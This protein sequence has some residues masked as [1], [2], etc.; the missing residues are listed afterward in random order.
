[1]LGTT[2][3][4][5]VGV[6]TGRPR[7][8][9]H[10]LRAEQ[11]LAIRP[12]EHV[13]KAVAVG[14]HQELA[15][16]TLPDGVHERRRLLRVVVPDVV[17]REL[18]MPLQRAGLRIERDDRVGVQVVAQPVVA[19][20]IRTGIADRPVDR[21]ELRIVGAG[22]PRGAAGMIDAFP[23]P[24]VRTRLATFRH[25]PE[26]PHLFAGRLVER[27]QESAHAFVAARR[28][29]DDEV[30]DRQRRAGG[31]VVLAPVGHLGVP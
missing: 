11:K 12:I 7:H 25:R 9:L 29:R 22:Q 31:V 16:L 10:V 27:R 4:R 3:G 8:V 28:S 2:V 1:M 19:D 17:R 21:I 18:E 30:A 13:E 20:E 6:Q 15:R 14:L 23:L 26:A 24:G 5:P